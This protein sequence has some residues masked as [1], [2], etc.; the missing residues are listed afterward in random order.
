MTST[1]KGVQLIEKDTNNDILSWC[2]PA[3]DADTQKVPHGI[4]WKPC[5]AHLSNSTPLLACSELHTRKH[6]TPYMNSS[7]ITEKVLE[8]RCGL[9]DAKIGPLYRY[10]RY[11]NNW[12]YMMTQIVDTE[13]GASKV[14]AACICILASDFHPSKYQSLLKIFCALYAEEKGPMGIMKGYLSTFTKGG[15]SC[16]H[17]SFQVSE[18]DPRKALVSPIKPIF[19]MFGMETIVIWVAMLIKKRV[20]IYC[21]SLTELLNI[22][23]SFPIIGTWHRQNWN[24][25][26]PYSTVSE[27]ELKDLSQLGVYVAGFTDPSCASHTDLYDLYIDLTARTYSISDQADFIM[28]KF[29]KQSAETFLALAANESEQGLIKGIAMKTKELIGNIEGLKTDHED[30]TYITFEELSR[31]KMPPNMAKF[32]FNVALAESMCKQ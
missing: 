29:H 1:L 18:H 15:M 22:I 30:G 12:Q 5:A 3:A 31:R 13:G 32:L 28:T 23:R 27:L 4:L 17:G 6:E 2:F 21:D 11:Q 24:L 16:K 10:S 14:V 8:S 26:R 20:F 25:L 19:E 7:T 9:S